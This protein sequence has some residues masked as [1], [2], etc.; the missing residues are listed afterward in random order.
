MI[1]PSNRPN[2]HLFG[3]PRSTRFGS[4]REVR[5]DARLVQA[6]DLASDATWESQRW[7]SKSK[8]G[9][10]E[11][12]GKNGDLTIRKWAQWA[13]SHGKNIE[14]EDLAHLTMENVDLTIRNEAWS[15]KKRDST[16]F[17]H[18]PMNHVEPAKM[19]C[20]RSSCCHSSWERSEF[21]RPQ[22]RG[23]V[24]T[25]CAA[26]LERRCMMRPSYEQQMSSLCSGSMRYHHG[27][28]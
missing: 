10:V 23:V 8:N 21:C 13:K 28:W 15:M 12:H 14:H 17:K 19:C 6:L 2:L 11:T 27:L 16:W 3:R 25:L 1:Q 4:L 22:K 5:R 20:P 9:Q 24:R 7:S 18:E 26:R